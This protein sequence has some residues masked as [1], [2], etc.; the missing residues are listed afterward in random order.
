MREFDQFLTFIILADDFGILLANRSA[1]LY[2]MEKFD[3]ALQ[4][5]ELAEENYPTEMMYKLKE[6]AARCHLAKKCYEKAL[7]SFK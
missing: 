5:I 1:A 3:H 7:F 6:R 2:H 4:D